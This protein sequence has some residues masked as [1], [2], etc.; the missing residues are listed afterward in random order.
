MVSAV[1]LTDRKHA[2]PKRWGFDEQDLAILSTAAESMA[3]AL[4][5]SWLARRLRELGA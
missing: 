4:E 2:A 3:Q 1:Q 5:R